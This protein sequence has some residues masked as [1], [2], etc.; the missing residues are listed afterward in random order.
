[1]KTTSSRIYIIICIIL[2]GALALVSLQAKAQITPV[3][4]H[5][6]IINSYNDDDPW[7]DEIIQPIMFHIASMPNV[8]CSI[9]NL[10]NA[11]I[12]DKDAFDLLADNIFSDYE[13]LH[14]DY[15]VMVGNFAFNLRNRIK[16]EWGDVPVLLVST[17]KESISPTRYFDPDISPI[18]LTPDNQLIKM[19]PNFNFTA[20]IIPDMYEETVDMMMK[21]QPHIN[22]LIFFSDSIYVN[23]HVAATIAEYMKREYPH[24]VF[25]WKKANESN[26]DTLRSYFVKTHPNTGLLISSWQYNVKDVKGATSI[27]SS[28]IKLLSSSRNPVFAM[29]KS[30]VSLGAVGGVFPDPEPIRKQIDKVID[31]MVA[32]ADMHNVPFFTA[33]I[34][35]PIVNYRQFKKYHLNESACPEDTEY[36]LRPESFWDKYIWHAVAAMVIL[37]IVIA[38]LGYIN[39]TQHQRIRALNRNADFINGMP[40]PYS[41]VKIHLSE[42]GIIETFDYDLKNNAFE[43]LIKDNQDLDNPF[44]LFHPDF[45]VPKVEEM[46]LNKKMVFFSYHFEKTHTYYDFILNPVDSGTSEKSPLIKKADMFAIDITARHR[47][48]KELKYASRKLDIALEAASIIPFML[49]ADQHTITFD[50]QRHSRNLYDAPEAEHTPNIVVTFSQLIRT[51][52]P[53]YRPLVFDTLDKICHRT[54]TNFKIEYR[55]CSDLSKDD[56][57]DQSTNYDKWAEVLGTAVRTDKNNHRNIIVGSI[58]DITSR[59]RHEAEMAEALKKANES[60]KMKSAFLASISHEIRTP[61]NAIVGFSNVIASLDDPD[62]RAQ[63][64]ELINCNND[65]LLALIDDVLDLSKIEANMIDLTIEACD[66]NEM[67]CVIR[68]DMQKKAAPHVNINIIKGQADCQALIDPKRVNQVLRNLVSNSCKFTRTGTI[69]VGYELE[70]SNRTTNINFFVKDS[71]IGI[72]KSDLPKVFDKFFK[73]DNFKPG[74]GLGLSICKKI[75]EKMGGEIGVTSDGLGKGCTFWFTVPYVSARD[76]GQDDQPSK[77]SGISSHPLPSLLIAEDNDNNYRVT[78]HFLKGNYRLFRAVDGQEAVNMYR[79][80]KPDAVLI[81]VDIP[82]MN[83]YEASAEIR[84]YSSSVP[85]I[86]LTTSVYMGDYANILKNGF[87]ALLS[88]PVSGKALNAVLSK[89]LHHN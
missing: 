56:D 9:V 4:R 8:G 77:E 61:L 45:I 67:L 46:L 16:K 83:G 11:I 13:Q 37:L 49:D 64:A 33:D 12:P 3:Q 59:K 24:V 73:V 82:V 17:L 29:R 38:I 55:C 19:R 30:Y 89:Y 76:T 43:C 10:N 65:H 27:T 5:L 51:V 69:N 7:A 68:N 2:S 42:N 71:G 86:A 79:R 15:I 62:K 48:E 72:S 78:R 50:R 39:H 41:N 81:N 80:E 88:H 57:N 32:G 23:R 36:Y 22:N 1:M 87:S 58:Q 25:K 47:I 52:H 70:E 6:L 44:V 40:V 75:V 35:K 84:K 63:Y 18:N 14:P 34:N 53:D 60:D 21:L 26:A 85:I 74:T 54:I 20:I 31:L 66:V 28:D